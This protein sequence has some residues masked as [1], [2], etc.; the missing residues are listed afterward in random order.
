[1]ATGDADFA[2]YCQARWC[3]I[4]AALEDE[5]VTG[6]TARM[7][8]AHELVLRRRR[9]SRLVQQEDV[10]RH[11]WE[12]IRE[13]AGLP[14]DPGALPP[15]LDTAGVEVDRPA[16]GPEPWLARA[17]ER[18]RV[19]RRARRRRGFQTG[20]A[21]VLVVGV[22]GWWVSR[23]PPPPVR[24]AANPLPIPWYADG[25]LHLN[26][27]VVGLPRVEAFQ[28]SGTGVAVRLENGSVRLVSADGEV[29]D[30]EPAAPIVSATPKGQGFSAADFEVL[31]QIETAEG[32]VVRVVLYRKG[33]DELVADRYVAIVCESDQ[34][35][36]HTLEVEGR[37]RFS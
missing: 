17:E 23:P 34:C 6:S 8:A 32:V 21:A 7:A 31:D 13:R 4:V 22:S 2:A 25:E 29:E 5:G 33:W 10:E 35:R 28:P 14:P 37:V 36:E 26:E 1:M 3:D 15:M 30:L 20:V 16:Q 18:R 9:W 12:A 27:V 11:L 19:R 24:A